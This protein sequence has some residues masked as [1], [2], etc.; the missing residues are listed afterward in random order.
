MTHGR[1]DAAAVLAELDKFIRD[2]NGVPLT[3]Q[4]RL[5]RK[6]IDVF[7]DRL[8][9]ALID[10]PA[11]MVAK[12]DQLDE[13]VHRAPAIPLTNEIRIERLEIYDLLDQLRIMRADSTTHREGGTA[14][15]DAPSD[16]VAVLDE[17][18]ELVHKAKAVPLTTQIRVDRL[19]IYELLDRLRVGIASIAG[20]DTQPRG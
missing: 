10:A 9:T 16:L 11:E 2:A 4:V 5:D 13:L 6:K 3:D 17:L 14:L 1:S 18:D 8:R 12:L 20:G 19:E 15:N 7:L